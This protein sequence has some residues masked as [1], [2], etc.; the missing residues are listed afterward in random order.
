MPHDRILPHDPR[1]STRCDGG[2]PEQINGIWTTVREGF[3]DPHQ[4]GVLPAQHAA[5]A[6]QLRLMRLVSAHYS[7]RAR[8]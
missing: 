2:R 7:S 8:A 6:A 4:P 5:N 3:R 1:H